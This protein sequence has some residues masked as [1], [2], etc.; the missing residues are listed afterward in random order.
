LRKRGAERVGVR[1]L[2]DDEMLLF[3]QGIVGPPVSP[4]TGQGLRLAL[5]T[6]ARIGEIAG[7]A[8]EELAHVDDA[9]QA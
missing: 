7:L 3:W 2:D 9:D 6:G 4:R 5:L 1:V 8:R